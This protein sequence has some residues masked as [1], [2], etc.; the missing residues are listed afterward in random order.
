M[1]ITKL[2]VLLLA[3]ASLASCGSTRVLSAKTYKL[4]NDQM[5]RVLV[6]ENGRI[7]TSEISNKRKGEKLSFHSIQ[8]FQLRISPGSHTQGTD[9]V[10]GAQDFRVG[11]VLAASDSTY[12]FE[13]FSKEHGLKVHLL[14]EL[15]KGDFFARKSLK[16]FAQNDITIE[17]VDLEVIGGGIRQ[18]YQLK[19]ITA[20]GPAQWKPGLGQ[21]LYGV[22]KSFFLGTEF[23]AATNYVADGTAYCG[24]LWGRTLQAG[25]V[26]QTYRSVIGVGG[27][28]RPVEDAFQAYI[29][30]VRIRPLRL[31]VQYNSWFDFGSRVDQQQFAKSVSRVHQE[32]VVKRGLPPLKAYVIDDGWQDVRADWSDQVWK[33]N[34]KFSADFAE[35]FR[36]VAGA[37]SRLGLWMSPGCLFGAQPAAKKLG[38]QGFEKLGNW[39][40]MAGPRY[41]GLL[42]QRMLELTR[43]GVSYFKLDGLFGHLN[44]REFELHGDRYGLPHMPQLGTDSLKASDKALNDSKYDELKT[45]YLVAGTERLMEIFRKQHQINPDV[46]IVISN[47]A[48]LSPWWLMYIDTVWMINAGDAAEGSSRTEELAYR[49]GVYHDIWKKE[50]TQ[51]P[52]HSVFNHEPKKTETGETPE[53]FSEYLWMNLSRGTGFVELYIKTEALSQQDWDVLARGLKWA[54]QVFPYFRNVKM[55]GGDPNQKEVYGYSGWN[56]SGGYLSVHNPDQVHKKTYRIR[57]DGHLGMPK[58]GLVYQVSSPL[59]NGSDWAG[60]QLQYGQEKVVSLE[61]GEVKVFDFKVL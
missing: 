5:S 51:F 10:I 28:D 39:M 15:G 54:H 53:A 37:K 14:Y 33:V 13:L 17:R 41:M 43:Q 36:L 52:M 38:E 11:K 48:Y 1:N 31:Q 3:L 49:D 22:Q 50:H 45:Y 32:L 30:R 4:E 47:G 29:D 27:A 8:E 60:Q 6:V 7:R 34:S 9:R 56:E 55:H 23:P 2:F 18:P 59:H 24:Y 35:S 20:Q 12:A 42:E 21:P 61:P 16:I 40:S 25:E 19:Q 46:Y 57:F 26:H 44:I 58:K